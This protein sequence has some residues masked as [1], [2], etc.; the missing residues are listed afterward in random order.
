MG[1][2]VLL[3]RGLLGGSGLGG[4]GGSGLGGSLGGGSLGGGRLGG[5]GRLGSELVLLQHGLDD[6]LFFDEEGTEDTSADAAGARSSTI[7]TGDAALA[8]MKLAIFLGAEARDTGKGDATVSTLGRGTD[9]LAVVHSQFSTR[10]LN[11][12][13][14]VRA[15]VV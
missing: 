3:G 14:L 6:L 1:S 8:A 4:L 5:L 2:L 7:S 10:G 13:D 9:L 11:K 12:L 15:G